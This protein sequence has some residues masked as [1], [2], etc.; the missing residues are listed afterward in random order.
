MKKSIL[1]DII[2]SKRIEVT[3]QKQAVDLQTLSVLGSDRMGCDTRSMRAALEPFPSGIVAEFKRKSP[4]GGWLH[5]SA[6]ITD[7]VPAHETRDAPVCSILT[8][9]GFLGDSLGDL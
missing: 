2:A 6:N 1:R 3:R 9:G 5:S 8:D 7:V 4:S